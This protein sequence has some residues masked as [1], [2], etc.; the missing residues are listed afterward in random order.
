MS[1]YEELEDLPATIREGMPREAQELYLQA[2]RRERENLKMSGETDEETLSEAAHDAGLFA[3]ERQFQRD[4]AGCW[5]AAP[6][7][8]QIDPR[9]MDFSGKGEK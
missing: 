8:E 4:D 6:V 1:N 3:V 9:K 2:F 7:G 5:Q